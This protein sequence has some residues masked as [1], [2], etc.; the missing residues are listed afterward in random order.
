MTTQK[1]KKESFEVYFTRLQD[2]LERLENEADTIPL[3]EMLDLYQESLKLVKL[4]K[5]KL[6]E[7]ELK[8]KNINEDNGDLNIDDVKPKSKNGFDED[9]DMPF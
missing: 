5:S 8:I 9:P 1:A 3:E 2:I 4:C 7:A 6:N